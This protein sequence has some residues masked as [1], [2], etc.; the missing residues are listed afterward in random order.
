MRSLLKRR[1]SVIRVVVVCV[2]FL[3]GA[4]RVHADIPGGL[5]R[6]QA[7]TQPDGKMLWYDAKQLEV[8]GKGWTDTKAFY[9]RLP[10]RAE[11]KVLPPSVW[12]LSQD[13]AGMCVRFVSDAERIAARWTVTS[14]NLAMDHMPATGVSGVD[15]YVKDGDRWRWIGAG[16]P[17]AQSNERTL[18]AGIPKGTWE[19]LLYLPLYN[20]VQ[21]LAIGIPVHATIAK[22]PPRP[23]D[24][25]KPIVYYGTS[26][27]QGGCACRP[28]MAHTSILG[29]M[30]DWHVIN[31]GFSGSGI[32]DPM[33]G[34]LMA[35]LDAAAYVLDCVP[36]MNAVMVQERTEP[37]VKALRAARPNVPIVLVENIVYQASYFLP[38]M[39]EAYRGKNQALRA[40]YERLVSA[41]V[42]NL[43]YVPCDTFL[44]EDGEATVDGTHCTDLGFQRFAEA[45]EPFFRRILGLK[46]ASR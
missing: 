36:N 38:E 40:A 23:G 9:H 4:G 35:E 22:A 5:D 44:G 16:R 17:G 21:S 46:A 39:R 14:R 15:L 32:L 25:G 8:E 41:G 42:G 26:I 24:R 3:I 37:F 45:L 27:A 10:A 20:G 7:T 30:L 6:K 43:H 1:T 34:T 11:G 12:P 29:R 2:P 13:T 18:A 28:G 33:V 19:Y 31:L